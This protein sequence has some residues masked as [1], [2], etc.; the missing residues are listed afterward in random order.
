[1]TKRKRTGR[2]RYTV[3]GDCA[4]VFLTQGK[5]T[6][7]D[8]ADIPMLSA[9]TWHTAALG[10][11]KSHYAV[12]AHRDE[13]GDVKTV[14][15]HRLLL[16]LPDDDPRQGDHINRNPLDNRRSNLRPATV[17]QNAANRGHGP[18]GTSRFRGVSLGRHRWQAKLAGKYLG[19]FDTEEEAAHA[20][21][22]AAREAWGE[23]AYQNFPS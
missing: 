20:Y 3:R 22:V 19:M 11:Q 6:Q 12:S 4:Y 2:L 8:L 14:K 15:M 10:K 23:Y 9:F 5:T 1:M 18:G 17:T 13:S 16:G 7:V 21:D